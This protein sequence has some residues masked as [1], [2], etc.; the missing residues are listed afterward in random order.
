M[1]AR[2]ARRTRRHPAGI[3]RNRV[4]LRR[5]PS[6]C[7]GSG[8]PTG[9]APY[10]RPPEG[11]YESAHR[12]VL[13]SLRS[14]ADASAST[15][16]RQ[17]GAFGGSLV[18]SRFGPRQRQSPSLDG[19]RNRLAQLSLV[20]DDALACAHN[21]DP[22]QRGARATEK[23]SPPRRL[24]I[25][26]LSALGRTPTRSRGCSTRRTSSPRRRDALWSHARLAARQH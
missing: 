12:S 3:G 8:R 6:S 19:Q 15:E 2:E 20:P 7:D 23:P 10:R 21:P 5:V 18:K 24:P 9:W 14:R 26:H 17:G 4:T 1:F 13:S 25:R 16:R 22:P 11:R